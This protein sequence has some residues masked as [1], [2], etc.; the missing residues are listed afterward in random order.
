MTH[1]MQPIRDLGILE[2]FKSQLQQWD[3]RNWM[4]FVLGINTGLRISD[5]LPLK[6]QDVTGDYIV[7]R[8]RKTRKHR[9]IL[10]NDRLR[11]YIDYYLQEYDWLTPESYMFESQRG[12]RPISKVQAYRILRQIGDIMGLDAVGTH[13]MR[14]TFGYH[15]YQ[16]TKDIATLQDIMNHSTPRMTMIYIGLQQDNIDNAMR[17]FEL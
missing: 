10:V 11:S 1:I 15:F 14:K 4:F 8:E 5:I 9:R 2:D 16:R 13:T 7:L 3:L 12:G 6:V 17:N